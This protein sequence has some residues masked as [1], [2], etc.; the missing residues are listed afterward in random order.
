MNF[1]AGAS[2]SPEPL[3]PQQVSAPVVRNPQLW[4]NPA[5]M[6]LKVPLGRVAAPLP[7]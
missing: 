3:W 6:A 7:S 2:V 5:P 1:P 4:P